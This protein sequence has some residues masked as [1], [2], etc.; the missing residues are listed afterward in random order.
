VRKITHQMGRSP[1][2]SV[3]VQSSASHHRW[4]SI[5]S[6]RKTT[7]SSSHSS[8]TTS[9]VLATDKLPFEVAA[10]SL[11]ERVSVEVLDSPRLIVPRSDFMLALRPRP[12]VRARADASSAPTLE[13][14]QAQR[15]RLW[16]EVG[17]LDDAAMAEGPRTRSERKSQSLV[18]K[19]DERKARPIGGRYGEGESRTAVPAKAS[20]CDGGVEAGRSSTAESRSQRRAFNCLTHDAHAEEQA[21]DDPESP[22][23]GQTAGDS[24]PAARQA[25]LIAD[26]EEPIGWPVLEDER[27]HGRKVGD[28]HL[29]RLRRSR[30]KVRG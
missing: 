18:R 30:G 9:A 17:P 29:D 23:A 10:P 5:T 7:G 12:S 6:K 27:R 26:L 21:A 15:R 22:G 1:G 2:A 28:R 11:P 19:K 25:N 14:V 13:R 8:S 16:S 20:I 3:L 24:P 4:F